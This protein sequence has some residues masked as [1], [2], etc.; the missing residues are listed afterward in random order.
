M[1]ILLLCLNQDPACVVWNLH[2]AINKYTTHTSRYAVSNP[3]ILGGREMCNI[4][5]L[6]VG[7]DNCPQDK[8]EQ[9]INEADVLHFSQYDWT[10]N[11]FPGVTFQNLMHRKDQKMVFHGHGGAWLLDPEPQIQRCKEVNA[12]MITCSPIDRM[13]VPDI[14]WMP[15]ILNLDSITPDW[16]RN[17]T[18]IL[19]A[20]LANG[21]PVYKGGEIASYVFEYLNKFGYDVNFQILTSLTLNECLNVR[22]QHHFT[23]D[24]WVQGFTGMAGLEGLALG[25][26][27]VA[28]L[29]PMAID[30]WSKHWFYFKSMPPFTDV[31][32]MDECAKVIREYYNNRDSLK[33]HSIRNRKWIDEYYKPEDVVKLWVELYESL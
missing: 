16:D 23:I 8:L 26:I 27:V 15:N 33:E 1:K 19:T 24:N 3:T 7:S 25:H 12:T 31:H 4:K 5:D 32:G 18:G 11:V 28:R 13:V 22:R 29:D 14:K 10:T 9:L 6:I 30:E 2:Q 17:F 20:S 21:N